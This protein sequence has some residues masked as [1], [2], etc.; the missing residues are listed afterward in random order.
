MGAVAEPP[1]PCRRQNELACPPV[2][3][4]FFGTYDSAVHPRVAVLRDGLLVAGVEID[5]CNAPLGLST[6]DKVEMLR[7]A[8]KAPR[9]AVSIVRAWCRLTYRSMGFH[10]RHAR[11]DAVVVGYLGHF[12]VH[13]ARLLFP[14]TPIVLDH[15]IGAT[16]T[17]VDRG[18]DTGLKTRVLRSVDRWALRAAHLVVVDTDEQLG[19]LDPHVRRKAVVVP[20]G[21][22]DAWFRDVH[23]HDDT[24]LSVVFF[25]LFTPLQG[26]PVIGGAIASLVDTKIQ[27]TMI[28]SGQDLVEAKRAAGDSQRVTW[29][30]WVDGD[31]LPDVVAHHD[32]CLGIF[33]TSPKAQSVV[34]NKVFQGA[35]AGCA[36]VT[37]DTPPQR[38]VLGEAAVYV[39]PGDP[40]AL[41]AALRQLADHRG[42]LH[43]LRH[44][45]NDLARQ[46]FTPSAV[47]RVLL[48]RI[49]ALIAQHARHD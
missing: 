48:T 8:W 7:H 23:E 38:R 46:D 26:T 18:L 24:D 33:G 5:E 31:D 14:R 11:P 35:A 19:S 37:S 41:A 32:V 47:V 44:R 21:A 12:D 43:A 9:L 15:L 30:D 39:P 10:Q 29:I 28:G 40:A 34:P 2:R 17:A 49:D 3:L 4:L 36:I 6:S 20:V 27:F 1:T 45:G 16:S 42:T 25:G 13:L 22:P